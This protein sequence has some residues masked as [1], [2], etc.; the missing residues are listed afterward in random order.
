MDR[1]EGQRQEENRVVRDDLFSNVRYPS[2]QM[3]IDVAQQEH[4]LEEKN[5]GRPHSG[6][7]AEVG[8]EHLA[9]HR[10]ANEKEER[11]EKKSGCED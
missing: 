8:K 11:A 1:Q 3:G 10:L 7:S 9:D 5:A 4:E 6:G 2:E